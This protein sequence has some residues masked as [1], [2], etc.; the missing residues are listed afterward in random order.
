MS[1]LN[2]KRLRSFLEA[3][4]HDEQPLGMFYTDNEPEKGLAPKPGLLPTAEED[5]QRNIDWKAVHKNWSCVLGHLRLA[6]KKGTPAYFSKDRWGCLGGAFF[7]GFNKPQLETIVRFVSTGIPDVL[8][9]EYYFPSPE[10]ARG[11]Y[12]TLDP[13]PAPERF[14]VFK[15][16]TTF[17]PYEV[18]QF[19]TFF[20]RPE[21]ISGLHQL[22]LFVTD[23]AEAVMSP[24]GA[25]CTNLV[26]W[27]RKY[28]A[29]GKLKACLGGWD[30]SCRKFLGVDEITFTIPFE[31]YQRMLD[32]WQESF[33][34][35]KTWE[36]V[37][38]RSARSRAIWG[39]D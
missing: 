37:R 18:P 31:M 36:F 10:A 2:D 1:Q 20:A 26:A 16:V 4:G 35:T 9:G 21:V 38:Q 29:Q 33:L 3:L 7:L 19:V 22:T 23:D 34:T 15:P 39:K 13:D 14:C 5:S 17:G 25:G 6:R 8:E 28:L 11:Y 12:E 24:W 27:P 30:P 32:H